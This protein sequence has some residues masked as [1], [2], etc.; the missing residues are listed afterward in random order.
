MGIHLF[1]T[2]PEFIRLY[3]SKLLSLHDKI[4]LIIKYSL[5]NEDVSKGLDPDQED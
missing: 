4:S 2:N 1:L 5:Q 3:P